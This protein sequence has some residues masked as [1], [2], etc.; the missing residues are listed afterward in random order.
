M[1]WRME[2]LLYAIE[3]ADIPG[4]LRLTFSAWGRILLMLLSRLWKLSSSDRVRNHVSF[5]RSQPNTSLASRSRSVKCFKWGM[6]SSDSI[7]K[8][9][10]ILGPSARIRSDGCAWS[11]SRCSFHSVIMSVCLLLVCHAHPVLFWA[12]ARFQCQILVVG[13]EL[14]LERFCDNLNMIWNAVW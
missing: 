3:L 4:Y 5:T 13:K 8:R 1:F 2:Y 11:V 14:P 9:K 12:V 10:Y 6:I 7:V